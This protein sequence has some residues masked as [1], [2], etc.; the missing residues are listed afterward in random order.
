MRFNPCSFYVL[1]QNLPNWFD[2]QIKTNSQL[3]FY[4]GSEGNSIAC[5][6]LQK[7]G[8]QCLIFFHSIFI[9]LLT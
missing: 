6:D 1:T 2:R 9:E 5:F 8:L 3:P 7:Q 4:F